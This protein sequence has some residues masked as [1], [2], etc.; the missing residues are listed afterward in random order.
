VPLIG[1][2]THILHYKNIA[3]SETDPYYYVDFT[4]FDVFSYHFVRGNKNALMKPYTVVLLKPTADKLFGHE[5]P[6]GKII[7][8]DIKLEA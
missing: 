4:F 2:E 1:I 7:T 8:V 5:D 6:V 3:I